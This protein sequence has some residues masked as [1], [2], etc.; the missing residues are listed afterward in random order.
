MQKIDKDM[1]G[2]VSQFGRDSLRKEVLTTFGNYKNAKSK[3]QK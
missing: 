3:P 2:K 1:G